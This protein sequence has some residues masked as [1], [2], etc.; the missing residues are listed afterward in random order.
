MGDLLSEAAQQ[1]HELMCVTKPDSDE[2]YYSKDELEQLTVVGKERSKL[3]DTL[4]ELINSY[5]VKVFTRPADS[6]SNRDIN[7]KHKNELLFMAVSNQRARK[8]LKMNQD[9]LLVYETI[10]ASGR[11]GI[12]RQ[13]IRNSTLL[14]HIVLNQCLDRLEKQSEIKS[15]RSKDKK[16]RKLYMLYELQPSRE[17]TGG[18]FYTD[19]KL[20]HDLIRVLS[21]MVWQ[22]IALQTYP[23]LE[24]VKCKEPEQVTPLPLKSDYPT[25]TQ[26]TEYINNSNVLKPGFDVDERDTRSL[27]EVLYYDEK[28]ENL[29]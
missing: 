27:C 8:K 7:N 13:K 23:D 10:E 6:N 12:W 21:D 15:V 26:I 18:V 14:H 9:E 20:D 19:Y 1:L 24:L 5:Y 3:M 17:N 29:N 16:T 28:L 2:C 11:A 25:I 4:Q 22:Y